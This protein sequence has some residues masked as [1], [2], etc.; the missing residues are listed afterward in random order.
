MTV[1]DFLEQ[2]ANGY[3]SLC[4]EKR[5]AITNF[6]L[7]WSLFEAKALNEHGNANAIKE[8]IKRWEENDLL[9]ET[10][11]RQEIAYFRN[12]YVADS[13]FTDHFSHLHLR[14]NDSPDLVKRALQNV[15]ANPEMIAAAVLIIVFRLRNNL[16][17]GVKWHYNL[18]NQSDNFRHANAALMEAIT[19]HNDY[20]CA[21]TDSDGT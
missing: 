8:T 12:R 20:I 18:Q 16:F 17:H 7:L 6:L 2:N 11:F 14:K 4:D 15:G 5:N 3:S 9:P 10:I 1:N 21:I 13:N 19:R